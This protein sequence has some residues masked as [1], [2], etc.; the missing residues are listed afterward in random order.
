LLTLK[1]GP[2]AETNCDL[3]TVGVGS[4]FQRGARLDVAETPTAPNA[5]SQTTEE[6]MVS[7]CLVN[8]RAVVCTPHLYMPSVPFARLWDADLHSAS[9]ATAASRRKK[10]LATGMVWITASIGL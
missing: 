1:F 8:K 3:S 9:K 7:V 6:S 10:L 2:L 5:A 4:V